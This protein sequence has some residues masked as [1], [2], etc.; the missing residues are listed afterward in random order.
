MKGYIRALP[1][2]LFAACASSAAP[3]HT[4]VRATEATDA[5]RAG[6]VHDLTHANLSGANLSGANLTGANLSHA[7]LTGANLTGAN[8]SH[9]KLRGADLTDAKLT[10]TNLLK[11]DLTLDQY[12]YAKARHAIVAQTPPTN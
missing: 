1:L 11:A 3:Q 10:S 9:A 6:T 5:I 4:A 12:N 8:F 7:N 2:L